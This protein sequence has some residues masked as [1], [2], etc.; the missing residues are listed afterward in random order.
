MY[1]AILCA[2][3]AFFA[4][5]RLAET[6]KCAKDDAKVAQSNSDQIVAPDFSTDIDSSGP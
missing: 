4:V 2:L 3:F 1:F 6:A 5:K